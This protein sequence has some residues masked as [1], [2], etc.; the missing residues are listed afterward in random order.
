M[1]FTEPLPQKSTRGVYAGRW[2]WWYSSIADWMIR[3]PG[4]SMSD[5]ATSLNKHAN[6]ISAIVNTDMFKEYLSRRKT[7]FH[8]EHDY[9]IRAKLTGVAEASLDIMLTQLKTKGQQIPMQRLESLTNSALDRLGYSPATSPQV[10]VNNTL[11]AR[12]QNVTIPGLTPTAL[13]EA[14]MALRMV[15]ARQTGSSQAQLPHSDDATTPAVGVCEGAG[16][17]DVS[18]DNDS[19]SGE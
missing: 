19:A 6:T 7:E 3:N 1:T 11:D 14:R 12:S 10:V 4:G 15:E 8:R 18:G 17:L 16:H 13:E 2:R 9:A 5:C